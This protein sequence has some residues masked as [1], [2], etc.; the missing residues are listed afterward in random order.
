MGTIGIASAKL[1]LFGEHASVYGFPAVG[2][3][4]PWKMQVF[5]SQAKTESIYTVSTEEKHKKKLIPLLQKIPQLFPE[6]A[7]LSPFSIRIVSE[8]PIGIGFGSSGALCVALSRSLYAFLNRMPNPK[9]IWEAAHEFEKVFHHTPSGVD[10]GLSLFGGVCAFKGIENE[11]PTIRSLT[12]QPLHLVVGA[13]PRIVETKT[14]IA[15]LRKKKKKALPLLRELGNIAAHCV[16]VLSMQGSPQDLG[17]LATEAQSHLKALSLS[18]PSLETLL[19]FGK[20]KGS[21]GGKL[22]GA[23]GGGAYYLFANS[24]GHATHLASELREFARQSQIFHKYLP[25]AFTL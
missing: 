14:L 7:Q 16:T 15:E 3:E 21:L 4:L 24:A 6:T 10:T 12:T 1:L 20:S 23:G 19:N 17:D 5:L 25:T 9:T 22:S 18:T 11:L 8:S 2:M 13:L